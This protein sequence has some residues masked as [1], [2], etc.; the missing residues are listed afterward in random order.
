MTALPSRLYA[1]VDTSQTGGRPLAEVV[2]AMLAGGASV[3]QLRVKDGAAGEFL[4]MALD[5]R[6]RTERAGCLFIVNDRV[7]I[8]LAARADGVHLGQ[9]DLPLEAARPLMG[10]RLIGISTHSVE[11]AEEAERGGA[12][13]IGFGPMFPTRTKETGYASRGPAML[14]SVRNR[15]RLPIV[16]IGGITGE[17]VAQTWESGADAAAMISYLTRGEDVA[18]RVKEILGRV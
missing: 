13:Y 17:N 15:V 2:E 4:R 12:D 6:E 5:A 16:A 14:R 1:I 11:Q 8:A 3:L 10:D 7:D 18:A 9:D